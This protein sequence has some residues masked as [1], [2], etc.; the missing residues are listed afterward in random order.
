MKNL[1]EELKEVLETLSKSGIIDGFY[2]AGGTA[3][4]LKYN[5]RK[6]YDLDFFTSDERINFIIL[7]SKINEIGGKIVNFSDDTIYSEINRISTSFLNTHT[8]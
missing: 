7:T 4:F 1:K 3:I 5:H 8:D 2:L 6:S